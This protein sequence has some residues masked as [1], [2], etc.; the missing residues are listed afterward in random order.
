M[1]AFAIL[2]TALIGIGPAVRSIRP[3]TIWG[4]V[5]AAGSAL[6]CGFGLTSCAFFLVRVIT[7]ESAALPFIA[8]GVLAAASAALLYG[9]V[10]GFTAPERPPLP[11]EWVTGAIMAA[12]MLLTIMS[13]QSRVAAAPYGDWDAWS[14]WNLRAKFLVAEPRLAYSS[15]LRETHPDYPMLVSASVARLWYYAGSAHMFAPAAFAGS[16][17]IGAILTA[18]GVLGSTRGAMIGLLAPLPLLA[19]P[20]MLQHL[21]SG[22][23]DVPL[24]LVMITAVLL[25]VSGSPVLSGLCVGFAAWTKN[26]GI[27]FAACFFVLALAFQPRTWMRAALGGAAPLLVTAWFKLHLAEP[28]AGGG[29][30]AVL[31]WN[32]DRAELI[33]SALRGSFLGLGSDWY[34]PVIPVFVLLLLLGIDQSRRRDG[35]FAGTLAA[36]MVISY[37]AAY[38]TTGEDL[39]WQLSTSVDRLFLQ[40][41]PL[42]GFA[43]LLAVRSPETLV[44]PRTAAQP[45]RAGRPRRG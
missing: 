27:A 15:M 24:G 23:A 17:F 21:S 43:A 16:L 6:V 2:I 35:A 12:A 13:F 9:C 5:A 3:V 19:S 28:S 11:R 32:A 26:E 42:I 33:V 40:V 18:A 44:V 22:Y 25:F 10:K 8:D 29:P 41:W 37:F 1:I 39:R 20:A 4:W 45:P 38:M 36:A 7:P 30:S 34:H 14:I 31:A